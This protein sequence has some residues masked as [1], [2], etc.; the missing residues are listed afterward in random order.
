[1]QQGV[2]DNVVLEAHLVK[3]SLFLIL[4]FITL[5]HRFLGETGLQ[6]K[7]GKEGQMGS[8][9]HQGEQVR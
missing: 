8:P 2:L 5:S 4:Q 9:G 7:E 3:E 6:G 1:M